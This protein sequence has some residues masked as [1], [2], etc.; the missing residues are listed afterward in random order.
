M[1]FIVNVT[2]DNVEEAGA[3]ELSQLQPEVGTVITATLTDPDGAADAD[4]PLDTTVIAPTTWHVW[5]VS[6]VATASLLI[7]NDE[8]HWNP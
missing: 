3:I 2:V 1:S 5:T 8:S 6:K 7:D 4:L